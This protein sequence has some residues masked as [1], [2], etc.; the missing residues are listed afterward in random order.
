[1]CEEIK[2]IWDDSQISAVKAWH[3]SG[4]SF[5]QIDEEYNFEAGTLFKTVNAIP[6]Y[7]GTR[8]SIRK[9][10]RRQTGAYIPGSGCHAA[11]VQTETKSPQRTATKRNMTKKISP[12]TN[13]TDTEKTIL[14]LTRKLNAANR[15]IEKLEADRKKAEL[16]E[17]FKD[18]VIAEY[19]KLVKPAQSKKSTTK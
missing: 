13:L 3:D 11:M 5:S 9:W 2:K 6:D 19:E 16:R 1:M 12:S 18:G 7:R 10:L 17:E 4:K 8:S 15:K 14:E